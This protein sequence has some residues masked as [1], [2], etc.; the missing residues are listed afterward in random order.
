MNLGRDSTMMRFTGWRDG[1]LPN[2]N[3]TS[4][5]RFTMRLQDCDPGVIDAIDARTINLDLMDYRI[6]Y[7]TEAVH[8][9]TCDDGSDAL[10]LQFKRTVQGRDFSNKG[11]DAFMVIATGIL[12]STWGTDIKYNHVRK[13]FSNSAISLS[14]ID[15]TNEMDDYTKCEAYK[16]CGKDIDWGTTTTGGASTTK[17]TTT[18]TTTTGTTPVPTDP[19][20]FSCVGIDCTVTLADG[21]EFMGKN[22]AGVLEFRGVPYAEAPIGDLR[23]KAPV[24]RKDYNGEAFDLR[25]HAPGCAT[26]AYDGTN[27]DQSEDC[28]KVA[29]SVAKTTV[30]SGE[31]VPIVY[32]IHG[33]GFNGGTNRVNMKNL[34]LDQGVMV[35]SIAYRLGMY[36]FF[37]MPTAEEGQEFSGNWGILDQNAAMEW[38]QTFAH[39]FGGDA[40]QATINGCSAGSESIWW[41]L[42]TEL[43]WPLFQRAVTVGI[44]MN[45]A[46]DA[47]LGTVCNGLIT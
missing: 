37:Y 43:S 38:A 29:I 23:W 44:G 35:I 34:I 30:E 46:Y 21:T 10:V 12:T 24:I 16:F 8:R 5:Y 41:H 15:D 40:S 18:K 39:H 47:A 7:T 42:T 1:F 4:D 31:K 6:R 19:S 20:T 17:T 9:Q 3:V 36:G 13:C 25:D 27:E 26:N 45:S 28:L 2:T 11:N 33:G 32:Y 14:K 22:R